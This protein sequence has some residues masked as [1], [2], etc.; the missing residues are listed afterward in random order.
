MTPRVVDVAI[1]SLEQEGSAMTPATP[2]ATTIAQPPRK[3]RPVTDK[4][5][6]R[7]YARRRRRLEEHLASGW[8]RELC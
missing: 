3:P 1:P 8:A 4:T 7:Y 6:D 2:A 5:I